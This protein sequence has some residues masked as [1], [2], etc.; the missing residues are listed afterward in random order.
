M[1][2]RLTIDVSADDEGFGGS[3]PIEVG[4]YDAVID[5]VEQTT[6]ANG[7]NAGK[8]MYKVKFKIDKTD[9]VAPGRVAFSNVCLWKGA[10]IS[11]YQLMEAIGE[12][13]EPGKVEVPLPSELI[14]KKVRIRIEHRPYNN[15][16]RHSV[17]TIMPPTGVAT[18]GGASGKSKGKTRV[19]FGS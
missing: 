19:A 13:I 18:A 17:K 16:M 14:G 12:K 7:D 2:Q 8:P 1:S 11:F 5:D 10:L 9:K 4:T 6:P 3:K 15:E